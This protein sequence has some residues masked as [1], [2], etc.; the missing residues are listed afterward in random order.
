MITVSEDK[1]V[2]SVYLTLADMQPGKQY[3]IVGGPMEGRIIFNFYTGQNIRALNQGEWCAATGFDSSMGVWFKDDSAEDDSAED[4]YQ[5]I[6]LR[7]VNVEMK[8]SFVS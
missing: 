4:G 2:P 3:L 5:N 8:Y 7:E 1:N 6:R